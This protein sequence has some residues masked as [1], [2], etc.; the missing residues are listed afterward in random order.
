MV[1]LPPSIQ[2]APDLITGTAK[3]LKVGRRERRR[4]YSLN[5]SVQR[6]KGRGQ[7]SFTIIF[8]SPLQSKHSTNICNADELAVSRVAH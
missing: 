7:S 3:K 8:L 6:M 5:S 2:Q 1:E 4:L